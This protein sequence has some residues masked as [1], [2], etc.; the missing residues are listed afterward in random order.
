MVGSV[1]PER[2]Y[3]GEARKAAVAGCPRS[4]GLAQ[5]GEGADTLKPS[6]ASDSRV[7]ELRKNTGCHIRGNRPRRFCLLGLI[8]VRADLCLTDMR[9]LTGCGTFEQRPID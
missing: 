6:W 4:G 1:N 9:I 5:G 7:S 8:H 2:G 3:G